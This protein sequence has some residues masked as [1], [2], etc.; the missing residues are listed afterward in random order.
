MQIADVG[1]PQQNPFGRLTEALDQI[2]SGEIYVATGG[3]LRCVA[4]G[5]IFTTTTP[6]RGGVGAV[7]DGFHRDTPK[8]VEQN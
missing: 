2:A 7:I 1:G 5:E 6:V 4:W 8:V 3:S